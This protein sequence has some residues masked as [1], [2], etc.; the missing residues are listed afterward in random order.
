MATAYT[1][2]SMHKISVGKEQGMNVNEINGVFGKIDFEISRKSGNNK[3]RYSLNKTEEALISVNRQVPIYRIR[4]FD[5]SNIHELIE[6]GLKFLS[7]KE[8]DEPDSGFI[9]FSK[10]ITPGEVNAVYIPANDSVE[11]LPEISCFIMSEDDFIKIIVDGDV[12]LFYKKTSLPVAV[13]LIKR[14]D[15]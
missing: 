8:N 5:T 2:L 11:S 9:A 12:V 1:W 10:N 4:L 14:L 3:K 7:G 15:R 6:S 13:K